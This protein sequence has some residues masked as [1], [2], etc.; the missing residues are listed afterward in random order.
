MKITSKTLMLSFE[1]DVTVGNAIEATLVHQAF[2]F[3]SEKTGKIEVELDFADVDNVKFMGMPIEEG[4]T[5][6]KK[7]KT[8]MLELGIDVDKLM[9]EKAAQLITDDDIETLR[10][11]YQNTV[12]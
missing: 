7:F 8:K 10:Q 11:L 5:G 1:H 9:D 6:Y 2:V 3:E 12:K 4:Y